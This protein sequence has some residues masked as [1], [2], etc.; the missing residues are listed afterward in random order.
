MKQRVRTRLG[1]GLALGLTV[2]FGLRRLIGGR[3][4]PP[5]D[6][7]LVLI[8]RFDLMGDVVNGLSAAMAARARWPQA[9]LAFMGPPAWQPDRRAL[10]GR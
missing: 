2:G 9:H 3:R 5:A 10:S 7:R 4:T 6:P 8:V 1:R